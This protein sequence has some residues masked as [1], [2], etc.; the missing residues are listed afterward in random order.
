MGNRQMCDSALEIIS[1]E[2]RQIMSPAMKKSCK[3]IIYALYPQAN[4]INDS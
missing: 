3:H 2:F 4:I 1:V